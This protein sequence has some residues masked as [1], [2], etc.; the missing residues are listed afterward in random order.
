MAGQLEVTKG[1]VVRGREGMEKGRKGGRE[2]PSRCGQS[3][4]L[5]QVPP[6]FP[7]LKDQQTDRQTK[8]NMHTHT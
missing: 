8:T 7:L 3:I 5:H 2:G 4:E 6:C 1:H